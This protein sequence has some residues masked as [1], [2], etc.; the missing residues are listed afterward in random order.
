MDLSQ[1]IILLEEENALLRKELEE[2]KEHLHKYTN[3]DSKKRYYEKNK[4]LIKQKA[5][6]RKKQIKE[7]NP[8]KIKEYAR[9]AYLNKKAK[10]EKEK[11]K[12]ENI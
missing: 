11:E 6:E 10:L 7:E 1:R 9:T 4:E 12:I 2:V 8:D 3:N 5:Q